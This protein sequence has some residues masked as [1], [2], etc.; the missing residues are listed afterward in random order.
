[1]LGNVSQLIL[2][3]IRVS[4]P[5]GKILGIFSHFQGLESAGKWF[6]FR[7]ILD[8]GVGDP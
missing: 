5:P 2:L 1:V 6:W 3:R 8:I 7:K 4:M